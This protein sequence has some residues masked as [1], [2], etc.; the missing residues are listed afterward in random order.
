MGAEAK[1]CPKGREVGA[2]CKDRARGMRDGALSSEAEVLCLLC[3][4]VLTYSLLK[5]KRH[6]IFFTFGRHKEKSV[7]VLLRS[8][9]TV[10]VIT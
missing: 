4:Y 9:D 10:I 2:G 3:R 8:H 5:H 1:S 7:T 6:R